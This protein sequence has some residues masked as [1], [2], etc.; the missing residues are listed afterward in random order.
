M[1]SEKSKT[2]RNNYVSRVLFDRQFG[3]WTI[4][5]E[6]VSRNRR[7]SIRSWHPIKASYYLYIAFRL[8]KNRV[9]F[10]RNLNA[11]SVHV[12]DRRSSCCLDENDFSTNFW[13][14]FGDSIGRAVFVSFRFLEKQQQSRRKSGSVHGSNFFSFSVSTFHR[15]LEIENTTEHIARD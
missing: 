13:K 2:W 15:Y 10:R 3:S 7:V 11:A 14:S 5:E 1:S 9:S 8:A 12:F 4:P 6:S